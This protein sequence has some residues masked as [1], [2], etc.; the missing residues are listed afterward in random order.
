MKFSFEMA[1]ICSLLLKDL[2]AIHTCF[3]FLLSG[4]KCMKKAFVIASPAFALCCGMSLGRLR[5]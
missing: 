2:I 5:Q 3:D 1:N 4:E